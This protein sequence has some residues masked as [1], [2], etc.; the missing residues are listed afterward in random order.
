MPPQRRL[1]TFER[2]Q[3]LGALYA[4]NTLKDAAKKLNIPYSTAQYTKKKALERDDEQHDLDRSGR[5]RITIKNE[6]NRL[7][8]RARRQPDTQWHELLEL[9][10]AGKNTIRRRFAEIDPFFKKYPKRWRPYLR[11]KEA[12]K[13]LKY[14]RANRSWRAEDWANV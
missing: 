3:L 13:R 9:T 11:P 1:K 8:R 14:A 4:G 12:I 2:S 6:E 10:S 5:P 7:Y